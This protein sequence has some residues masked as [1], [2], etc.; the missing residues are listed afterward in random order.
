MAKFIS[1]EAPKNWYPRP[2]ELIEGVS[3]KRKYRGTVLESK[4]KKGKPAIF[5]RHGAVLCYI[6]TPEGTKKAI[7]EIKPIRG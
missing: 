4:K 6:E 5:Q 1:V 2:G 3:G 7:Y